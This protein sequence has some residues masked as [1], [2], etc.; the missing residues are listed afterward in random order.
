MAYKS[1]TKLDGAFMND[2]PMKLRG[3]TLYSFTS[4][5]HPHGLYYIQ[6]NKHPHNRMEVD[7]SVVSSHELFMT[8]AQQALE[9]CEDCRHE[10]AHATSRWP[11]AGEPGG[12]EL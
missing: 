11:N 8:M 10:E 9:S 5:S 2:A 7:V 4:V 3:G 6:C 12:A 1:I